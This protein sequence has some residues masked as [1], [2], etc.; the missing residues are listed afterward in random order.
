MLIPTHCEPL[1]DTIPVSTSVFE[2]AE[3]ERVLA[4]LK[5]G[6]AAGH[7]GMPPDFWKALA[8]DSTAATELL[9]IISHCWTC[10]DIPDSWRVSKVVLLF[11]KGDTSLPS[12]YR[13][14][15]LLP[16]GYKVLA[17]LLHQ[18]M[19]DGGVDEFIHRAQFGFRPKRGTSDAL[20]LARRM[21]DAAYA[22]KSK[23]LH[24][25][26]LDSAKAFDRIKTDAMVGALRRFGL[27]EPFVQMIMAIYKNRSFYINDHTGVS[28][29]HGLAAGIALYCSL[30]PYLFIIVQSVLLH[31]IGCSL[32][33]KSEPPFITSW[34]I[35]YADDTLLISSHVDN[36]QQMLGRIVEEGRRYGL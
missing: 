5:S 36:L 18:R 34:E 16:V 28:S 35:L 6:K 32:N 3:L 14:I 21:I 7:D 19:L 22:D 8:E 17:A 12:N 23:G 2:H 13:P 27:P 31:D 10:K 20:M 9:H 25:L 33:L 30:S 11:K 29:V 1:R 26:L 4:K 24:L 15:S